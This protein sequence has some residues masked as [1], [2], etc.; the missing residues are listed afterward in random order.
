MIETCT[1]SDALYFAPLGGAE[2]FGVNLNVYIAK[3]EM[4]IVDCGIGFADER[5]PGIDLLLPDPSALEEFSEAIAGLFIT[6]AHED[7][8]G[9]VAH[10]WSRLKCPLYATRFTAAILRRKL[11]EQ[12]VKDAQI[13]IVPLKSALDIGAFHVDVL[14]VAHSIPDACSLL[15]KANGV[16]ALHSG[17]WNLDPAPVVGEKTDLAYFSKICSGGVDA[18][19]G[20]STNSGVA[21]RAGS[22]SEIEDGLY[23]EIRRQNGRVFVTTF[24]SNI[25]RLVSILR[26]AKRCGRKIAVIGL[27]MNRMI[28]AAIECG[29][30]D[31]DAD[32][33]PPDVVGDL[34]DGEVLYICTGSQG[35][36]RAALA[37]ISR[38]DHKIVNV[39][40]GDTVIFSARTI[41]GNEVAINE[42]KN[43]L[44]AAGVRVTSPRD[45]AFKIHVSGHPCQDEILDLWGAI[46]PHS[47]IPVHGERE[48][49]EAHAALAHSAQV[50]HVVVPSNGMIIEITKSG[51]EVVD[52]VE[53]GVLA[54]DQKRIIH[55]RHR[56]I[57]SR[58]KLQYT[59]TAFVS[60][61]MNAKG[62]VIGDVFLE[63]VGLIDPND[64]ED[65][66]IEDRL[67]DEVFETLDGMRKNDRKD[68]DH[69]AD[70]I[71]IRVRRLANQILG[72]RPKTIVHVIEV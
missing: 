43:D 30:M 47:V 50:S 25:G 26:A 9:A 7:H 39:K 38:G 51:L 1:R 59:G 20:D 37:R 69:V 5:F 6:H 44:I 65:V 8:I 17:D 34:P 29:Y 21:G 24:S 27:S 45:S 49:L 31:D 4:L 41:P 67:Y 11:D 18:Y 12:N 35:E 57:V 15:I 54:V 72:M 70:Q 33:L 16:S 40:R 71:R 55:G 63:T 28:S 60:L 48:Q 22:E 14:P 53:T 10:L 58:R 52:H 56:S 2:Q 42:I 64:P 36:G 32:I 61:A 68:L 13:H 3:G 62:K 66:K 19:I 23:E 46:K